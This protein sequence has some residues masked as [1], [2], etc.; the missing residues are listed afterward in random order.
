MT[1]KAD[2]DFA[3]ELLAS[4]NET[5]RFC[6]RVSEDAVYYTHRAQPDLLA[7]GSDQLRRAMH[8]RSHQSEY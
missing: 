6:E 7:R 1:A 4:T 2:T 8:H 3:A 5:L